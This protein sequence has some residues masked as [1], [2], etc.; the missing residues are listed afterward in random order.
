MQNPKLRIPLMAVMRDVSLS[1]AGE[2]NRTQRETV[3]KIQCVQK[4]KTIEFYMNQ[5]L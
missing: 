2:E 1:D 5:P 4:K 3:T